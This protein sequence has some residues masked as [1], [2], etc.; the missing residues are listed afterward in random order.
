MGCQFGHVEFFVARVFALTQHFQRCLFVR[1]I[2]L[3][4]RA[5]IL[6]EHVELGFVGLEGRCQ[7]ERIEDALAVDRKSVV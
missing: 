6:Q 4:E 1:A 7:P 5:Q 3:A 2:P